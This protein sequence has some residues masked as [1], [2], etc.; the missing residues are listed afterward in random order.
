MRLG[1]DDWTITVNGTQLPSLAEVELDEVTP[2]PL[3]GI[4]PFGRQT[5]VRGPKRYRATV[6]G[7]GIAGMR[8]PPG[9]QVVARSSAGRTFETDTIV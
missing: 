6:R 3:F 9:S 4:L 8:L 7:P 1:G 5:A 2:D